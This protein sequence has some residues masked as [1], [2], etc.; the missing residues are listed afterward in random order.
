MVSLDLSSALTWIY[1][2]QYILS[3]FFLLFFVFFVV[4][5]LVC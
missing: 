5:G 2:R 1:Q 3:V 4:A